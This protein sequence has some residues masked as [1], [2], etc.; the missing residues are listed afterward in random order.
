M[1]IESIS[2]NYLNGLEA[3][4]YL[5]LKD[6]AGLHYYIYRQRITPI[7]IAGK[8]FYTKEILAPVKKHLEA[9]K[10]GGNGNGQ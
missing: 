1:K 8:R 10:N 4:E 2:K 6:S 5:G 7:V 3:A 9:R